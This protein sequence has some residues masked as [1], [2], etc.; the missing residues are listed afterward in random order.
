MEVPKE[1][2]AAPSPGASG[3]H[4]SCAHDWSGRAAPSPAA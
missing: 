1:G 4:P 2:R 3:R